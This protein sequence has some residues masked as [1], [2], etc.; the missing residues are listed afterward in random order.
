MLHPLV[1]SY[2]YSSGRGIQLNWQCLL[3]ILICRAPSADQL[4]DLCSGICAK[5]PVPCQKES[6]IADY[7]SV[8]CTNFAGSIGC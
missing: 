7:Q 5:I 8:T 2:L 6:F 4:F 3:K 1:C